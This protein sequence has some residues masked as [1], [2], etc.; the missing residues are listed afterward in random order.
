[1]LGEITDDVKIIYQFARNW[2]ANRTLSDSEKVIALRFGVLADALR[3]Q[4]AA[5]LKAEFLH[6]HDECELIR[7]SSTHVHCSQCGNINLDPRHN[8]DDS[9]WRSEAE[10]RLTK[11]D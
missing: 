7:G 4:L 6:E 10:R 8:Y 1:M 2:S 3:D 9:A 11:G 5:K